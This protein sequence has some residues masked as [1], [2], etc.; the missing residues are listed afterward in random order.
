MPL[1]TV[2]PPTA[3]PAIIAT[4][5]PKLSVRT[6]EDMRGGPRAKTNERYETDL[7]AID[8]LNGETKFKARKRCPWCGWMARFRPRFWSRFEGYRPSPRQDYCDWADILFS[9]IS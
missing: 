7:L 6:A 8:P 3:L 5:D 9:W 4:L 1:Y 2:R